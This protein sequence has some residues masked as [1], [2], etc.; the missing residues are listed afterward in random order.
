MSH[1]TALNVDDALDELV[2]QFSDPLSFLRELVQNALDAGSDEVD[3][4]V[5]Y[6]AAT[7]GKEGVAVIR[8]DDFGVGMTREII[9]TRL[10]RLF[11][12][13]KDGDMTKIG[14]FGIGFVSV[15]A[16]EPDAV[17][18]DTSREGEHWRILFDRARRFELLRREEPVDGTKIAIYKTMP[19]AAF[20]A[21][22]AR[23]REVVRYWCRHTRGEIRFDGKT[24][25]EP[26]DLDTSCRVSLDDGFSK[27]VVGHLPTHEPFYG[28][29]NTGLTL[30]EGREA[31]YDAI[32]FKASSPHLEHTLTRD[33]VIQDEGYHRILSTI[34]RAVDERLSVEVFESLE[35][36]VTGGGPADDGVRDHLYRAAAWHAKR[37]QTPWKRVARRVAFVAPSG[38]H[39][40]LE[41][42]RGRH[43]SDEI[44]L[45]PTVTPLTEA[46]ERGEATVVRGDLEHP[47]ADLL[48][49]LVRAGVLVAAAR[50]SW[51]LP[52][53]PRDAGE[54]ERFRPLSQAAH[55]LL[56]GIGAKIEGVS[57][58]HFDYE[59]SSIADL[60]AI[61]Q[62]TFGELTRMAE[63]RELGFG[64]FTARRILVVNA[65]HPAVSDLVALAAARSGFAAYLLCKLFFLGERLDGELDGRLA[66]LATAYREG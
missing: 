34:D 52:L 23:A 2:G 1:P 24:V 18:I 4:S 26:F 27:I 20:A 41:R 38:A 56:S 59:G 58:A 46:L 37:P 5:C 29:Y 44:L 8:V 21:F 30:M 10:T 35:R 60:I 13:D 54:A 53:P 14:K 50:T 48:A 22:A 47:A 55:H 43:R 7:S 32:A 6:E 39:V 63:I 28:F 45:A 19:R 40:T 3:V 31:Y 15:F 11:S 17:C 33:A 66:S 25:T 9:E 16:I 51:A 42:I 62:R 65:D 49:Q 12:S 57:L 64:W 36:H 61:T